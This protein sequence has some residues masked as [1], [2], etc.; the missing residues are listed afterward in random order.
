MRFQIIA[1]FLVATAA[2]L[3]SVATGNGATAE[4]INVGDASAVCG[5]REQTL[6]CCNKEVNVANTSLLSGLLA[7]LGVFDGCSSLSVSALIGVTDLLNQKCKQTAACCGSKTV[8]D[9]LVN[10]G[11]PC[12]ALANLI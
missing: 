9:G 1:A 2:A 5:A 3:P 12:V 8:Q 11:L 10:I 4:T 6:K 7:G